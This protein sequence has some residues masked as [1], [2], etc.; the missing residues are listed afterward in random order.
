[1]GYTIHKPIKIA[2]KN[3]DFDENLKKLKKAIEDRRKKQCYDMNT[4]YNTQ[5]T[6]TTAFCKKPEYY[7]VFNS[8]G[9][10]CSK[11][12]A[13]A[14]YASNN[15]NEATIEYLKTENQKLQNAMQGAITKNAQLIDEIN[16]LRYEIIELKGQKTKI[17]RKIDLKAKTN[18]SVN[19]VNDTFTSIYQKFITWLNA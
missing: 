6:G 12:S 8:Q 1:M 16:K 17:I 7:D 13:A 15:M 9:Y 18:K 10:S 3:N 4:L 2:M 11:I 14:S 5:V 19:K